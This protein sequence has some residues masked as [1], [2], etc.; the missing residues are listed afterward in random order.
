MEGPTT[1]VSESKGLR[2]WQ[3]Q[4]RH[5]YFASDCSDM[6]SERQKKETPATVK[7]STA[8]AQVILMAFLQNILYSWNMKS[9]CWDQKGGH[10]LLFFLSFPAHMRG[11]N[12]RKRSGVL[13]YFSNTAQAKTSVNIACIA[14]VG[15]HTNT[16][17]RRAHQ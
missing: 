17:D 14:R 10:S 7:V 1:V 4:D 3:G 15:M 8:T 6:Y 12:E 5:Y 13:R 9:C 11:R 16:K 2:G